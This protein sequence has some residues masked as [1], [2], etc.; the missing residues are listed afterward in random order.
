MAGGSGIATHRSPIDAC[1]DDGVGSVYGQ[2]S[3]RSWIETGEI[4]DDSKTVGLEKLAQAFQDWID[5]EAEALEPLKEEPADFEG[6]LDVLRELQHRLF[7]SGW[8]RYGW[9]EAQGGL[10]GTVLHRAVIVDVLESNGFPPRHVFEHL[11]ILPPA[12]LRFGQPDLV[13]KVFLPTLRGDVLW[14]QGFSEPT[15]GSDLAALRTRARAV[16]G[17]YRIDGHKIWTSWAKW[18]THCFFLARTGDADS[19]HRGLSAFVVETDVRGLTV[20]AIRQSN[21]T[22]ELAEVFFDDVFVP[23]ASRVGEEGEGWA[24]AMYILAG[25]RGSYTWLRQCE[26]L[27]RLEAVAM[28][29]GADQH[30]DRIGGS[31][32][33]LISLRSRAREVMEILAN[34]DDPGPESSVSKVLAIDAEQDFYDAARQIQAG[35]LDLGTASELDFWQEHYLY[36]RASSVYGG[37]RQIQL[38]VIGKL[39]TSRGVRAAGDSDAAREREALYE[40]VVQAIHDS[41]DGR[42]ALEGLDWWAAGS[43][44]SDTFGEIAFS[45]WFE[46]EGATA[47]TSPALAGVR[48]SAVARALD[49]EASRIG[50]SVAQDADGAPLVLGGDSGTTLLASETADGLLVRPVAGAKPVRSRAFDGALVRRFEGDLGE[51]ALVNVASDADRRAL[52]LVRIAAS[53]EILGASRFLLAKAIDHANEREQ[54]GQPISSFQAIQHLISECQIEIAA[55]ESVVRAALEEWRAGDAHDLARIVKAQAGRDGRA[56][57]QRALQCFGAIGFTDDHP[58]HVYSR[59]IHTLDA[60]FG[61]T[62]TLQRGLGLQIVASGRAPRGIRVWRPD[63]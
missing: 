26:I 48:A 3:V 16:E 14:C 42:A 20:G 19:R 17:G 59:R 28:T 1:L 37:S 40:N 11:D 22:E 13:E 25:E 61:D 49:I 62:V 12:L 45:S 21:G 44:P 10:G 31:L 63:L 8:A 15:A 36:S 24:V 32:L 56:I 50:W 58:H 6:K 29:Q 57:A 43:V 27:P 41:A 55:L 47:I 34:G 52:D 39:M 53:C 7:D 9:P 60:C 54:F 4:M 5:E 18:A 33:R 46:A 2:T 51:P 23:E 35:A 30:L 38:N